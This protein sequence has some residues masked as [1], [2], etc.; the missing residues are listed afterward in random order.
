M[1]L[2]ACYV[3]SKTFSIWLSDMPA[4]NKIDTKRKLG[5]IRR[6]LRQIVTRRQN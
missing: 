6:K 5:K 1:T 4:E 3:F 2:A